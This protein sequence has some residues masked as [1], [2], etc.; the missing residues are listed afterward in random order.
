MA[1]KRS[2]KN[3]IKS[4]KNTNKNKGI[5]KLKLDVEMHTS[6]NCIRKGC[7]IL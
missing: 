3:T 1:E 7:Q 4:N 2:K 6:K 5:F